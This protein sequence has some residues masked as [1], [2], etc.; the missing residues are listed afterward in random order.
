MKAMLL[1]WLC[2]YIVFLSKQ[3]ETA[4]VPADVAEQSEDK[5]QLIQTICRSLCSS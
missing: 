2:L 1:S 3:T 5:G 4:N